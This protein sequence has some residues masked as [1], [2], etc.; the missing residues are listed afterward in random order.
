M[1]KFLRESS[2]AGQWDS[3]GEFQ[4]SVARA[5]T[6]LAEYALSRPEQWILKMVQA[7]VAGEARKLE[8]RQFRND[9]RAHFFAGS[10]PATAWLALSANC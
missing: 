8:V 4:V 7:A 6:K 2:H 1:D 10:G 5:L 3:Q 9:F